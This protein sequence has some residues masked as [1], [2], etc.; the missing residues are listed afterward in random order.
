MSLDKRTDL[1]LRVNEFS[2][3]CDK[4]DASTFAVINFDSKEAKSNGV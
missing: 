3:G 1:A 2:A 4:E